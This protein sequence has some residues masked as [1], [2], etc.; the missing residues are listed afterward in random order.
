[1]PSLLLCERQALA[2]A[3]Q[4]EGPD[5]ASERE[6]AR[7]IPH[8]LDTQHNQRDFWTHGVKGTCPPCS[9]YALVSPRPYC[10]ITT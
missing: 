1:M 6:S 4:P 10:K 7:D 8:C 3:A 9:C 5:A 2:V